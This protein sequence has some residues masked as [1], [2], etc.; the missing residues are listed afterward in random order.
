MVEP[1]RFAMFT[2]KGNTVNSTVLLDRTTNNVVAWVFRGIVGTEAAPFGFP[3]DKDIGT[4]RAWMR[5]RTDWLVPPGSETFTLRDIAARGALE[6]V[7]PGVPVFGPDESKDE[8]PAQPDEPEQ[9]EDNE[10][11]EEEEEE[12]WSITV[13][14]QELV[15]SLASLI[16]VVERLTATI[17]GIEDLLYEAIGRYG[18]SDG[19]E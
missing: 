18:D 11:A 16:E 1:I 14:A 4:Q 10:E 6:G 7:T 9:V 19:E 2:D 15:D 5:N 3:F 8:T 13:D 12:G 17:E